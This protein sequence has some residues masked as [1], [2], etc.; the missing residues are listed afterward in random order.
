[1]QYIL[2][3][4]VDPDAFDSLSSEDQQ[5]FEKEHQALQ[6]DVRAS[7]ELVTVGKLDDAET[8]T[9]IRSVDGSPTHGDGPYQQGRQFMGGYYLLDAATRE[10][11]IALAERLPEAR[12]DGFAIEIRPLL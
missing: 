6:A 7:G 5:A 8:A 11:A 3:I 1:M 10:R 12:I 4:H 2:L 9:I